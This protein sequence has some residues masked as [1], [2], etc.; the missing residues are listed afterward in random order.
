M[1]CSGGDAA[2]IRAVSSSVKVT[3]SAPR[4]SSRWA[5]VRGPMIGLVTP[6]WRITQASASCEEVTFFSAASASTVSST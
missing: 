4:L 5:I 1:A 6:G 2:S 3:S